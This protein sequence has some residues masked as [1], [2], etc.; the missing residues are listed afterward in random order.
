MPNMKLIR[1]EVMNAEL[2]VIGAT[3]FD[4]YRA[5]GSFATVVHCHAN[6]GEDFTLYEDGE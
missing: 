5:P 2:G 6:G 4:T 1:H 3:V